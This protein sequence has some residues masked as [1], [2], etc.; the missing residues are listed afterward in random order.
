ML[1]T[2][3][4]KLV[5]LFKKGYIVLRIEGLFEKSSVKIL[6]LNQQVSTCLIVKKKNVEYI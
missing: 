3:N 1:K 6:T 2:I 4:I 5:R